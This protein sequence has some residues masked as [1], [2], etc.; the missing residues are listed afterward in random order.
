MVATL[1]SSY[2]M[3]MKPYV[4]GMVA[5]SELSNRISR[6]VEGVAGIGFGKVAVQ[7]TLE[8]QIKASAASA[9]FR[10]VTILDSTQLQDSYPQY[11]TAA[12]MTK[13][14]VVVIASA[15]V[16]P[17]DPAYYVPATGLFTNVSNSGANTQ[18]PN[19]MWD[20]KTTTTNQLA[21]LRLG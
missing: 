10:G 15:A 8:N 3:N 4:E 12:I 19:A 2:D 18:I 17:G 14:V 16:N 1:Q 21:K 6:N 5:N 9:P 11:T 13:G 20:S 7:G